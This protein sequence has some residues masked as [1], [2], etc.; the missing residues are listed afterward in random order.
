MKLTIVVTRGDDFYVG[1][2]KEIPAVVSQGSSVEEAKEMVLDALKLYLEE[3][4]QE[5][6]FENIV[7][8]EDLL[9]A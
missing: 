1:T 6:V 5:K 4:Q 9:I 2:I 8:E 3:M 7:L